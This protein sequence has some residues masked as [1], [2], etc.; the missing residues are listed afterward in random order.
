MTITHFIY[1]NNHII[2][3]HYT[4]TQAKFSFCRVTSY[5]SLSYYVIMTDNNTK[6][7]NIGSHFEFQL[8]TY[9][10]SQKMAENVIC[11]GFNGSRFLKTIMQTPR[12]RYS[13]VIGENVIWL[14]SLTPFCTWRQT[15]NPS[16]FGDGGI[17]FSCWERS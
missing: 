5:L 16:Q 6:S 10:E 2:Y 9:P 14:I 4:S 13:S 11:T 15:G 8:S 17:H 12:S 1:N 7:A 3:C